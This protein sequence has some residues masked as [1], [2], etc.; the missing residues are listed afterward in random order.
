MGFKQVTIPPVQLRLIKC[1]RRAPFLDGLGPRVRGNLVCRWL[2]VYQRSLLRGRR[3][4]RLA[5]G[6]A[7]GEVLGVSYPPQAIPRVVR[8][9]LF[10]A[11]PSMAAGAARG[12]CA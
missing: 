8:S 12:S 5:P 10:S 6:G 2:V 4:R 7:R 11:A 3:L 1:K 9:S